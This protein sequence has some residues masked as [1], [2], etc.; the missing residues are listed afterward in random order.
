MSGAIS[1]IG[2][3]ARQDFWDRLGAAL[4]SRNMWLGIAAVEAVFTLFSQ[5]PTDTR[6]PVL[7]LTAGVISSAAVLAVIGCG[8]F[9]LL[10]QMTGIARVAAAV[11]ILVLAGV[12]RGVVL[13]SVLVGWDMSQPTIEG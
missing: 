7:N 4:G 1:R 10:R 6:R 12:A 11:P 3:W 5:M 8:W 13:Q 2:V 9:L